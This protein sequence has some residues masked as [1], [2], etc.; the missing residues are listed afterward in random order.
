[1]FSGRVEVDTQGR[2]VK[3][4]G[5]TFLCNKKYVHGFVANTVGVAQLI[6]DIRSFAG[7]IT[8]N[9]FGAFDQVGDLP[10]NETRS[11]ILINTPGSKPQFAALVFDGTVYLVHI[12]ATERHDD[13]D[14]ALLEV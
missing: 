4:K 12:D 13:E 8:N 1:M 2:Y 10:N 14:K 3:M 9:K 7:K 5:G 11:R 6:I